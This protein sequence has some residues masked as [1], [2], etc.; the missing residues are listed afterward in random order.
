MLTKYAA[1]EFMKSRLLLDVSP[2]TI[3]SYE[4]A[5]AKMLAVFPNELPETPEE[6]HAVFTAFPN[7]APNSRKSLW[8]RLKTFCL[9]LEKRYQI[10]YL[11]KD[12]PPPRTRRKL[13]RTLSQDQV[14]HLLASIDDERDYA[15]FVLLLDTGIRSGEL[16]SITRDSLSSHAVKVSGKTGDRVVP[17]SPGVF[18]LVERQG[19]EGGLW[20]RRGGHRGYLGNWGLQRLV[21]RQLRRAGFKPPKLGPHLLRHTFAT[22]YL[23]NGGNVFFLQRILGHENVET[24]MLYIAISDALVAEQHRRFSPMAHLPFP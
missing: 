13:P 8:Q 24:T 10:T 19:D 1:N 7:L 16:V 23:L 3:E 5:M 14:R 9:W 15:I 22:Q 20:K 12:I 6:M 4:W 18:E 21:R 2:K 17:L 11:M